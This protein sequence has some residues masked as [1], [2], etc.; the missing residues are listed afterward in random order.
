[1]TP[2]SDY[3]EHTYINV[4]VTPQGSLKW[5]SGGKRLLKLC[6]TNYEKKAAPKIYTFLDISYK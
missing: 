2:F 1:M 5:T 6:K 4:F 3:M